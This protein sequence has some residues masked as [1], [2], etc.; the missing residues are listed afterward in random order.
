MY[1]KCLQ[2]CLNNRVLDIHKR[3]GYTGSFV[4]NLLKS[5]T[6]AG[7]MSEYVFK[8]KK[9]EVEIELKSDD[10]EFIEEQLKKWRELLLK[11]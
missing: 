6:G 4:C 3:A 1:R 9:G 8:L 5:D 10:T 7:Y 2:N 11:K